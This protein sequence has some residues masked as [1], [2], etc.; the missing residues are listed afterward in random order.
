VPVIHVH[1]SYAICDG[2]NNASI[3]SFILLPL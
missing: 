3:L 1:G 2:G